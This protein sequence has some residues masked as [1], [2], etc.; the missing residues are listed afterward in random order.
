MRGSGKKT[1]EKDTQKSSPSDTVNGSLL[2]KSL[3]INKGSKLSIG[4]SQKPKP[5]LKSKTVVTQ[6]KSIGSGS[7]SKKLIHR[8][9]LHKALDKKS[10]RKPTFSELQGKLSS[11]IGSEGNGKTADESGSVKK[12]KK[13][14]KPNKKKKDNVKQDDPSRL[15]GRARYLIIKM[16][17]EQNLI[18]A[19]SGEGWK[20]QRYRIQ[21]ILWV[22]KEHVFPK[23]SF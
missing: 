6:K 23:F 1:T 15:H 21:I 17:L 12:L 11:T 8:K 7:T 18:D 22:N 20:G 16:K 19:Y 10:S 4:K 3:K 9:I 13:K 14:R 2:I 5:L